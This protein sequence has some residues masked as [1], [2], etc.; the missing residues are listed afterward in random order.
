MRK[1]SVML[2][3]CMLIISSYTIIVSAHQNENN[4][5]II[6]A[7]DSQYNED[8]K[9]IIIQMLTDGYSRQ[10]TRGLKCILF[11]HDYQTE[12]VTVIEHKVRA[13]SPRCLE[14]MYEVKCCRSCSDTISTLIDST[15]AY[16]CN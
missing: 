8:Q 13:T 11:G 5:E 7:E 6:F 15:P 2:A 1:I 12:Y 9:Q 10:Q 3:L 4:T 14:F 16:C